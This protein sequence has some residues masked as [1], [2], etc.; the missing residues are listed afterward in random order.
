VLIGLCV[1][2]RGAGAPPPHPRCD[3]TGIADPVP[4]SIVQAAV[5]QRAA[6]RWETYALGEPIPCSDEAGRLTCW[7]VPVALGVERFPDLE[8]RAVSPETPGPDG[9]DSDLW[10]IDRF[11]TFVVSASYSD[12]PVFVHYQG[13]PPLLA[14]FS[15]ARRRAG[16]ILGTDAPTLVRYVF[17]GQAG[18]AYVFAA[19]DGRTATL[20]AETL[21]ERA[22]SG[23]RSDAPPTKA[24]LEKGL[25]IYRDQTRE[26]WDA[27]AAKAREDAP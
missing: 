5:R 22:V 13:L 24:D 16:K 10:G 18:S 25:A 12:Y 20:D 4:L 7:Q 17:R 15:P 3:A 8:A 1:A 6:A 27:I 9:S 19:P 26:A 11:W 21:A 14:T 23:V 2:A